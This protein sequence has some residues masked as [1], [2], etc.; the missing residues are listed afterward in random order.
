MTLNYSTIS[1]NWKAIFDKI[2]D[3]SKQKINLIPN[4]D[5][6]LPKRVL[7]LAAMTY[8]EPKDTK[9]VIIGQ[10]PYINKDQAMGLSF[11]VPDGT[12]IPPSL[13]NIFKELAQDIPEYKEPNSGNL[14]SWAKQGVLLLNAS[15][16]VEEKKSNSHASF[17]NDFTNKFLEEFSTMYP[18]VIYIL[19]G[20]FAKNKKQFIKSGYIVEGA[21][22][23]PLAGGKFFGGKYFSK[24]NK[25]LIKLGKEPIKW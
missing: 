2:P 18:D 22:P 5:N 15:L 17:W 8:F 16:T 11:S 24:T 14:E 23:S 25:Q 6:V 3:I 4:N 21:H 7:R 19:W 20:N 1:D 10:D 12:K 9:V 13:K